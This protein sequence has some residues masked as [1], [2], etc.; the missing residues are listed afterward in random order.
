M[1]GPPTI[2]RK[3]ESWNNAVQVQQVRVCEVG[4]LTVGSGNTLHLVTLLDGVRVGRS[5]GGVDQLV[6]EALG[7]R[8]DVAE[9]RLAG[10]GGEE[11]DSLVDTSER[12]NVNSLSSDSTGRADSGR[13]LTGTSVDN[14]VN[15]DLDRVG[16]REQVD[17][18]KGVG[19]NSDGHHLLAVVAAVHHEPV[20]K[21]NVSTS[22]SSGSTVSLSLSHKT[23]TS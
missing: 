10:T 7:D 5:L 8:L 18:L 2:R 3:E 12:R 17:D 14:G 20:Q 11:R 22:W 1:S 16:V 15:E 4:S 6:S 21:S 9:G 13:V 23:L 19:D